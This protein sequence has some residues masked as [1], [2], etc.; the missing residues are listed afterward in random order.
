MLKRA[1]I[2]TWPRQVLST[3]VSLTRLYTDTT[4]A[5]TRG[6]CR[7]QIIR[8]PSP[9]KGIRRKRG[10]AERGRGRLTII[11]PCVSSTTHAGVTCRTYVCHYCVPIGF[12]AASPSR[13]SCFQSLPSH[14]THAEARG[15]RDSHRPRP[16]PARC[17]KAG[18][19][20]ALVSGLCV[21]LGAVIR[22]PAH[23]TLQGL[24]TQQ[25]CA[26]VC[27]SQCVC[28]R[29]CGSVQF[30]ARTDWKQAG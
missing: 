18:H 12:K 25:L 4:P 16:V 14:C 2:H 28:V 13:S 29:V 10:C 30:H 3:R 6:S 21:G 5:R 20:A 8:S 7:K 11:T 26:S 24:A 19:S 1:G 15:L 27:V 22:V 9:Q 23:P 17:C